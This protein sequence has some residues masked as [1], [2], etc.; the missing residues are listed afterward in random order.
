MECSPD[1]GQIYIFLKFILCDLLMYVSRYSLYYFLFLF[2]LL[3]LVRFCF[4]Q[5]LYFIVFIIVMYKHCA[6]QPLGCKR[7]F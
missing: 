1:V 3:L 4:L 2:L 6:I 7:C 5:N